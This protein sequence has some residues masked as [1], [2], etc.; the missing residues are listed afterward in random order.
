MK[1][2]KHLNQILAKLDEA[3]GIEPV[4][5]EEIEPLENEDL[6]YTEKV[7][8]IIAVASSFPFGKYRG[9]PIDNILADKKYCNWLLNQDWLPKQ[10][11]ELHKLILDNNPEFIPAPPVERL[12][13][14]KVSQLK[15]FNKQA[16]IDFGI[17][18]AIKKLKQQGTEPTLQNVID[19]LD[20]EIPMADIR[21]NWKSLTG[22]SVQRKKTTSKE[23]QRVYK[24][25]KKCLY[26]R[27]TY[28]LTDEVHETK[29]PSPPEF[30]LN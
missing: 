18:F 29:K 28:L 3:L 20:C 5:P 21:A 19:Y 7:R 8:K 1:N 24:F 11:P 26:L 15:G 27:D 4:E 2:N 12:N 14:K 9:E 10:H 13:Y 6:D 30:F 22:E 16:A 17:T 25:H 23:K